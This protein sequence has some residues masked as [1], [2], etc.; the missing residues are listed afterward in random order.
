[1]ARGEEATMRI[2][3][4]AVLGW[5]AWVLVP[6]IGQATTRDVCAGG[7][8][9]STIQAAVNAAVPGDVIDI[10]AGSY[11]EDVEVT[12]AGLTITGA[13]AGLTI[14]EGLAFAGFIFRD[15]AT[16][17]T[18]SG[19]T[20]QA[21]LRF[22]SCL[23]NYGA[24]LT[25][26]DSVM[27]DCSATIQTGTSYTGGAIY[28]SGDLLLERVTVRNNTA[29]PLLN[30]QGGGLYAAKSLSGSGPVVRIMASEFSGNT[31]L[32]GG[33][34][35]IESGARVF[36]DGS[37]ITG[38]SAARNTET[39]D[40]RGG[41]V[42]TSGE[43]HL[44]ASTVSAN[45]ADRSGGGLAII[46]GSQDVYVAT[47]SFTDNAT[48]FAASSIPDVYAGGA[49]YVES[50]GAMTVK[51]TGFEGNVA[52]LG[53]AIAVYN[54]FGGGP[55]IVKG[56][57]LASNIATLG[58]GLYAAGGDPISLGSVTI[59]NNTAYI[60]P[61]GGGR[62]GGLE[63]VLSAEVEIQHSTIAGNAAQDTGGGIDNL[64]ASFTLRNTILAGNT[65]LT[66]PAGGSSNDCQGTV[67]SDRYN[68]VGTTGGCTVVAKPSDL[69]GTDAAPVDPLLL[70]LGDNGGLTQTMWLDTASPAIDS[71][72]LCP[73][74][75]Q[76]GYVRPADGGTGVVRCD[77]GAVEVGGACGAPHVATPLDPAG[78]AVNVALTPL[79][80]WEPALNA[81]T[82]DVTLVTQGPPP[83]NLIVPVA[84]V[85]GITA[86][87]WKPDVIL[88][89]LK[90]YS[91]QIRGHSPCG[92]Q[93]VSPWFAF[94]T[95][96]PR[97]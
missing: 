13:G 49:I 51:G 94:T 91:W 97:R 90:T 16:P 21:P 78:G 65:A 40:G 30:G 56:S 73:L 27:E 7:C 67:V 61:G 42:W 46:A 23:Y 12:V 58:G 47:S 17:A 72:G 75:D 32:D 10:R 9:Y 18:L 88:S 26:R 22:V 36:V 83:L 69:T 34:I 45:F 14:V 79:F 2:I 60:A 82:Y 4:L 43:L 92:N 57:S 37:L 66:A 77:R 28:T 80:V 38:N 50:A 5:L 44:T 29:D 31:A 39:N 1:M 71:G 24:V 68:L 41:G 33:A 63:A 11:T 70:P 55:V 76:R 25:V 6:G 3:R 96:D 86:T 85:S 19:V 15:T 48:V 20:L 35:Y 62:G 81:L 84:T 54:A 52:G 89:S 64:G 87:H 74:L 53:G 59:A 8:S 93:V 95:R